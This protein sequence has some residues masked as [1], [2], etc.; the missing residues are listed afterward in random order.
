MPPLTLLLPTTTIGLLSWA[1]QSTLL[2][3]A[4]W[5]L[6]RYGLR[7]ERFFGFNCRFLLLLP[8]VALLA[9]PLLSA[10]GPGLAGWLS[11]WLPAAAP[12]NAGLLSGGLLPAVA[13]RELSEGPAAGPLP[14]LLGL[15][16]TG[17]ALLLLRLAVQLLH[18]H[19]ST[20]HLPRETHPDYVL[21]RT[22]GQR[23]IS[24]FGRLVFWDE[25]APLAPAEARAVLAHELA[26]V[27]GHHTRQRLL[28][29]V[30]RALLWPVPFA[31]LLPP[32][33]AQLHEFL[34]DAAAVQ[35]GAGS[36]VAGS[37]AAGPA[38]YPA[39]LA[40][41]ALGRFGP[42]LPLAHSFNSSFTLTRIRMLTTSAPLRRWKRWLPLPLSAG[43]LLGLLACEKE[44]ENAIPPPPPP[45]LVSAAST[46][47]AARHKPGD[48]YSY[49]EQMPMYE[50]GQ[51]QLL[52][53][54]GKLVKYPP[55]ALAAKVEGRAFV[56]FVV[57]ADGKISSAEVQK[58][59]GKDNPKVSKELAQQLDEAAL[60]AVR[61]LPGKWTPGRQNG[62]P[63]PVYFTIPI[64]FANEGFTDA[65][66]PL[67]SLPP[68]TARPSSGDAPDADTR[69]MEQP[70]RVS[71]ITFHIP[72][73]QP[74]PNLQPGDTYSAQLISDQIRKTNNTP[75]ARA[76]RKNSRSYIHL[77][78]GADSKIQ[79]V[80]VQKNADKYAPTIF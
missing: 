69:P 5:L 3:G 37:E 6:Y 17:A 73:S 9:P 78:V 12:G 26:H 66:S 32:A 33:L 60:N 21:V 77:I 24:S 51:E 62:Q 47:E 38:A 64:T 39:L 19:R 52:G 65:A 7:Q 41:L 48:P 8:W 11:N 70:G 44:V 46:V 16:A 40:R 74:A 13:V 22:G 23:P 34:A 45:A 67:P 53:D 35:V 28:L 10:A 58:G 20:R 54:I 49:V 30:A 2:L 63:V 25:T 80:E 14:W 76:T 27:R 50:G 72:G 29:E 56:K 75:A 31:H 42:D 59:A 55:A 71:Y 4:G 43:L 61:N 68:P 18:L 1:L 36:P 79:A 15:Y 57:G